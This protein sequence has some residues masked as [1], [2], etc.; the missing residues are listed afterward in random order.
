MPETRKTTVHP[1]MAQNYSF[2]PALKK[3][4]SCGSAPGVRD[5]P[6]VPHPPAVLGSPRHRRQP[7]ERLARENDDERKT[8]PGMEQAG[9]RAAP[10]ERCEPAKQGDRFENRL[11]LR[12]RG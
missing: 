9:H 3:P 11:T 7:I 5:G 6:Q 12:E 2:W 4:T 10:E 8:E 1:T